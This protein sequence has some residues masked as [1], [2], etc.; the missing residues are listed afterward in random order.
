MGSSQIRSEPLS[1]YPELIPGLEGEFMSSNHIDTAKEAKLL[2]PISVIGIML[3]I[4]ALN[5]HG[6]QVHQLNYNNSN[7]SDQNLFGAGTDQKSGI[8][9][10]PTT[11]NDGQH[12]YYLS[13]SES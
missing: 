9:G 3:M 2:L 4:F 6:Q 7:W 5:A 8:A 1:G 12:V 13:T 10:F 11:P